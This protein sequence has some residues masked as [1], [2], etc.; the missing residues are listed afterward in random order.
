MLHTS[1]RREERWVDQQKQARW[2]LTRRQVLWAV[3]IAAFLTVSV[4]I[5]Y[6]YSITLWDWIKLLIVPAVI[7]G[8]G[9]WFNGQQRDREME[10]AEQRS[11]D[12]AL[13]AY[14]DGM[15]D[16]LTDKD[17]PLHR[18][19][20]GD[21]LSSVARARTLTVLTRLDGGRKGSVVRFLYESG[22]IAKDHLV[23]KLRGTDLS[24]TDLSC[25]DLHLVDL[26]G[27]CLYGANVRLAN[28]SGADLNGAYL[29]GT[30]LTEAN[31]RKANL[32]RADLIG[33]N[34]TG[35]CL[36]GTNL[37]GA[38]LSAATGWTEKQLTTAK[39]LEGTSM[40]NG[41]KYEEWLQSRE[42]ESNNSGTS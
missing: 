3:G 12:E 36:S 19:Q 18:A 32:S 23:F 17:R 1:P 21:S 10:T 26:S 8:G 25:A 5:G 15:S 20:L 22:L 31:L 11:Q 42:E 24:G 16:L 33:I 6:R 39:S 28:L 40:P 30:N 27:A 37:S 34:L 2:Q 13:Q 29:R 41:Q 9:I 38:D 4:L 7:A 35:A 14:L